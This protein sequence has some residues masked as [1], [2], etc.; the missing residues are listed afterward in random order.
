MHT[1]A[2]NP[3][4]TALQFVEE[5]RLVFQLNNA[6]IRTFPVSVW[7][8][9]AGGVKLLPVEV[10]LI[11]IS[12]IITSVLMWYTRDWVVIDPD[13]QEFADPDFVAS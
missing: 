8:T 12:L 3:R 13:T 11:G 9:L 10:L 1:C 7:A 5:H 4:L 6:V 2:E